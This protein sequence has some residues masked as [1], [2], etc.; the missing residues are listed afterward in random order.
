MKVKTRYWY[1]LGLQPIFIFYYHVVQESGEEADAEGRLSKLRSEPHCFPKNHS[2]VLTG[3]AH[4]CSRWTRA[5]RAS[6]PLLQMPETL[7][8]GLQ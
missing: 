4:D 2:L 3:A 8:R 1:V 7:K 5:G 6:E